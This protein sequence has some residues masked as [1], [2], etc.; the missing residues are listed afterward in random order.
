MFTSLK[1]IKEVLILMENIISP[2]AGKILKINIK[3]GEKITDIDEELFILEAM[4]MENSIFLDDLGT[5]KEIKV[6]VGDQVRD[7][8]VLAIIE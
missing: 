2:M 8:D 3:V 4:K 5:V 7:G 1:T 6:N